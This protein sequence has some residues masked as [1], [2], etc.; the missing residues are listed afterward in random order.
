MQELQER[1]GRALSGGEG[2]GVGWGV[3]CAWGWNTEGGSD[4]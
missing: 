2:S 1:A 4:D 3:V